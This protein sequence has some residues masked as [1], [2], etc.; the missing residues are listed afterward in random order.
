M[1]ASDG[2]D[3]WRTSVASVMLSGLCVDTATAWPVSEEAQ[4]IGKVV[5]FG[6]DALPRGLEGWLDA[7]LGGYR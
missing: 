2:P 3:S 6:A 7:A 1:S 4:L 5:D